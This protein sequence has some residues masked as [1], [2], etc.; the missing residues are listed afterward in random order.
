MYYEDVDLLSTSNRAYAKFQSLEGEYGTFITVSETN[1]YFQFNKPVKLFLSC[2]APV[3]V[4]QIGTS[5]QTDIEVF[6][7]YTTE[8]TASFFYM[9]KG[10]V[11]SVS[12]YLNQWAQIN[13]YA[14]TEI[15][16]YQEDTLSLVLWT[17]KKFSNNGGRIR[18]RVFYTVLDLEG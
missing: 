13:E 1:A 15:T 10:Y 6:M 5:G 12:G 2:S 11:L 16:C 17:N 3:N 7:N 8:G 9:F 4:S 14:P 18:A